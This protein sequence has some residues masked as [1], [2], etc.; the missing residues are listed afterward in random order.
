[1]APGTLD[2]FSGP[3]LAADTAGAWLIGVDARGRFYL[4]RVFSG[5]RGKREYRLRDEPRAVAVGYGAVWVIVHGARDSEL[6]RIDRAT[7]TEDAP[8][9]L[10]WCSARSGS[11][12]TPWEVT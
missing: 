8:P 4:T 9:D 6:L 2:A 11:A 7:G 12:S 1:M 3:V 10:R 5:P